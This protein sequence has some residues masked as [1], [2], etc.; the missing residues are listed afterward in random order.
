[1]TN[2][3]DDDDIVVKG[4][5]FVALT[6]PFGDFPVPFKLDAGG[7]SHTHVLPYLDVGL[8]RAV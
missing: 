3:K 6:V 1:M 2:K 4:R 7:D 5:A 8:F